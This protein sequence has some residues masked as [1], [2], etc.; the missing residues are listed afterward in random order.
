M[1]RDF[2]KILGVERNAS[3]EDI[4]KA[5]R[6][7]ALKWHPDRNL[8]NKEKAEEKFKEIGEAYSVLSDPKKDKFMIKLVKKDYMDK[9]QEDSA[10]AMQMVAVVAAKAI[11]HL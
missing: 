9:H 3:V 4:K 1:A 6:K 2:Y 7:L 8:K 11:S 10:L 5:Y